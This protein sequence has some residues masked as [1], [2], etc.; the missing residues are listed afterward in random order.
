MAFGIVIIAI[1]I[2]VALAIGTFIA[3]RRQLQLARTQLQV[4]SSGQVSSGIADTEPNHFNSIRRP[5]RAHT[6]NPDIETLPAY[7]PAPV[8]A[9]PTK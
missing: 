4:F 8:Y 5:E 2:A 6:T 7:E 1:I 3:R 9:P